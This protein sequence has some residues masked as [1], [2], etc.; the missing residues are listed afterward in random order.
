M[1]EF[2][3][4]KFLRVHHNV[5]LAT[6]GSSKVPNTRWT[7]ILSWLQRTLHEDIVNARLYYRPVVGMI[8][9]VQLSGTRAS[10]ER[11]S[12]VVRVFRIGGF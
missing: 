4:V 11:Y 9:A 12:P 10:E 6:L 3:L 1:F 5:L 8:D 7:T 2:A